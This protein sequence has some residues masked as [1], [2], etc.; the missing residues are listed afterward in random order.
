[1]AEL[2]SSR[3]FVCLFLISLLNSLLPTYTCSYFKI[4]FMPLVGDDYTLTLIAASY[5]L[6]NIFGA[7]VW[8][9]FADKK[10]VV[11]TLMAIVSVDSVLKL[12]SFGLN[13]TFALQVFYPLAGLLDKG[14]L[15][16]VSPGLI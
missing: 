16:V 13:T 8:G 15:T 1:M 9:Y 6:A 2:L 5:S 3:V 14:T 11:F 7:I 10:G 4:I 12:L